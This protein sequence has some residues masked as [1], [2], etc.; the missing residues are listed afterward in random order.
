MPPALSLILCSRNDEYMGNSLW[1]LETTLN[2]VGE[3]VA[4]LGR[5]EDVEVLV[6]DWGSQVPLRDVVALRPAAARIMA[7][8]T[9]P[10]RLARQQ[11]QDSSFPEV[12]ALNAA[13]RCARGSYIGRIDQDTLVGERFLRWLFDAL[14]GV[15]PLETKDVTLDTALLFANRRDIPYRFAAGSPSLENVTRFIRLFGGSLP[16]WSDNP[17]T[18]DV[19]WTSSVGIWLAHRH[20]WHEC[21]GYDERLI[22]Y[23][24]M[25]TD[26]IRRLGQKYPIVN[27]GELTD[28]DFYHLEH[29]PPR[30][31]WRAREHAKKNADIDMA[32]PPKNFSPNTHDWGLHAYRLTPVPSAEATGVGASP[33][34][35]DGRTGFAIFVLLMLRLAACTVSDR[36]FIFWMVHHQVWSRRFRR[37]R[38]E[39]AGRPVTRWPGVVWGLWTDRRAARIRR[40][41]G[42][43]VRLL[44]TTLAGVLST[45]GLLAWVRRLR[46]RI[47]LLTVREM[48]RRTRTDRKRFA[49]FKHESGAVLGHRLEAMAGT[50]RTA[51][52]VSS[53]CPS[54]EGELCTI[55]ALQ[56]AGFKP[57]ILLEDEQ[58]ALRPYYELAGVGEIHFWS[59]FLTS[60]DFSSVAAAVVE[61]CQTLE[62][63][64][65]CTHAG[66]RVGRIAACTALRRLRLGVLE[67]RTPGVRDLLARCVASSMSSVAEAQNILRVVGPDLVL[68]DP[69]YTP[70]GELFETCLQNGLDVVAYDTAHRSNALMLKRYGHRNRD[71]HLTSLS[72]RSWALV[73]NLEWTSARRDTL[74]RELASS[75][76][77][78]DWFGTPSTPS[79]ARMTEPSEVRRFLGLDPAKKTACIFPPMLWD[80]PLMWG[81]TLFPTHEEW[82]IETVSAACRNDRVN[83]VIKIHP[84]NTWKQADEKYRGDPAEVRV[85]R[86]QLGVL[87]RHIIVIPPDTT[88]STFSLLAVV[89]YCVTVRGT[90]GV[91]AA[92]RGIP[93]L[94]AGAARYAGLGFTVD[95]ESRGE[96]LARLARIQ[97]TPPLGDEQ[98]ELAERFAY[99]LFLLR[100]LTLESVTWEPQESNGARPA[101]NP[102]ARLNVRTED[103]WRRATDVGALA[104]WFASR[105]EDFL[106]H[107]E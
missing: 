49:R 14:H 87:P 47:M 95:S 72:S 63:L 92:T 28:H 88:M 53:R 55:K 69:E 25:E 23:N 35:D 97:T 57:V 96:Y 74:V 60:L 36:M 102:R 6:T 58:S 21:G 82:L 26:M 13:A 66:V 27:L 75:Y 17:A 100:P 67:L 84:A 103:D 54:V 70:K 51:L 31:A 65:R 33:A 1:R 9:V 64:S 79:Q 61:P 12:L 46:L 4:A 68:T 48:R 80:A 20:L 101:V 62:D 22:Y 15:R 50:L 38:Q 18:G 40:M 83:W 11:Q 105:D 10:P 5:H 45:V 78:G 81:T 91:E 29:Y 73:R 107:V 7:F 24:W 8:V 104:E 90:V 86:E 19:F 85:L 99:G 59:E 71:Q 44:R 76:T 94:T 34:L 3:R 89:D 30:T 56:M 106:A 42:L 41:A 93:V 32:T 37:V 16:V 98:R 2:Y 43:R 77:T 52:V 39:L